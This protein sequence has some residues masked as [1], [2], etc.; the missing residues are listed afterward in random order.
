MTQTQRRRCGEEEVHSGLGGFGKSSERRWHLNW[1]FRGGYD[2]DGQTWGFGH[3]K[4]SL[5]EEM[6]KT[7]WGDTAVHITAQHKAGA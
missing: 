1:D 7:F 5:E 6:G 3:S 4:L 2:F